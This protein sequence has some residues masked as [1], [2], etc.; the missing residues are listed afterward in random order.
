MFALRGAAISIAAFAA[1]Y[2]VASMAVLL[3]WRRVAAWSK[4]LRPTRHAAMLFTLRM[5]PLAAAIL[6]TA[7]FTVP[8]F[9]LF[10]PRAVDESL[11]PVS[12]GLSVLGVFIASVGVANALRAV[13]EASRATA[14]W[15]H[16]GTGSFSMAGVPVTRIAPQVPALAVVGIVRSQILLSEAAG[17]VLLPGELRTALQHEVAHVRRR[18]NLKKL[19]VRAAVFPGMRSLEA[20]WLDALEIAADDAAVTNRT[21]ALDLAAAII[22][23]SRIIVTNSHPDLATGLVCHSSTNDRVQRLLRW[24]AESKEASGAIRLRYG[25]AAL[26]ATSAVFAFTYGQLLG[27][28]HTATEWLVR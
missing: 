22:K 24:N 1:V 7:F 9:L 20:A 14:S 25:I 18:D 19:L 5:L 23:L 3:A 28:V 10:E 8:S 16:G 15:M 27:H 21:E 6:T 2:C 11:S 13:A 4:D 17:L 26:L 12:L